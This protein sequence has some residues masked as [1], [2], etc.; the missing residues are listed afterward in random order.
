MLRGETNLICL[1]FMIIFYYGEIGACIEE[2]NDPMDYPPPAN[3]APSLR[4]R[5]SASSMSEA[6]PYCPIQKYFSIYL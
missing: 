3:P 5:T 1:S 6:K 2:Y 4:P